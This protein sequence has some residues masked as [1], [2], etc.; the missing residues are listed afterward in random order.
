MTLNSREED[1]C[2]RIRPQG[3]KP[4]LLQVCQVARATG[5][6]NLAFG[7][8]TR[9]SEA[10]QVGTRVH[11]QLALVHSFK[12]GREI[13]TLP[14][15]VAVPDPGSGVSS[16]LNPISGIRDEHP[17]SFFRELRNSFFS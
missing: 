1:C 9:L 12:L 3:V 16:S 7:L 10:E 8:V 5:N 4:V 14:I 17:R 2:P 6:L 11:S 15:R 13:W